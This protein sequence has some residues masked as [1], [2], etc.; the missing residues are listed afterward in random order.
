MFC[1]ADDDCSGDSIEIGELI[2]LKRRDNFLEPWRERFGD[3]H[4]I[5]PL[6]SENE[7]VDALAKRE[8]TN[9]ARALHSHHD[10]NTERTPLSKETINLSFKSELLGSVE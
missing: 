7:S 3:G 1:I 4:D 2:P 10:T 8:S 9:P 5:S 6:A